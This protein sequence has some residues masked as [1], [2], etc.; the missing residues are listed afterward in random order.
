M[1]IVNGFKKEPQPNCIYLRRVKW[2]DYSY[3]I[4]FNL[5][6]F[7]EGLVEHKIG[8]VKIAYKGLSC[9]EHTADSLPDQFSSLTP[10]Y[11]S[12]GQNPEYYQNIMECLGP[13]SGA[14]V[15][16]ALRDVVIEESWLQECK[17][18]RWFEDSLKRYVSFETINGQFRRIVSQGSKLESYG[19]VFETA[20]AKAN[21]TFE[22]KPGSKP[23]TNIHVLTGRNGAG[24]THT[25]KKLAKT[26]IERDSGSG[27]VKD[28][29]G[30]VEFYFSRTVYASF[31]VFDN[32]LE[33]IKFDDPVDGAP[34][35]V[36]VGL[37]SAEIN[38][39]ND[40]GVKYKVKSRL[41]LAEEFCDSLKNCII[42]SEQKR[43]VWREVV[44]VLESDA[45]FSEYSIKDLADL[46]ESRL[47]STALATFSLLSSGHAAVLYSL[48]KIVELTEEKTVVIFD[49]PENHLHPPLLSAF[50]RALSKLLA[51]KNGIAIMSTHSPVIVQE[52]PASCVW[53]IDRIGANMTA[54]RPSLETF[55]E[56]VGTLTH[57]VFSL[58]VTR[59]G[60]YALLDSD[61]LELGSYDAVMERYRRQIGLEGRLV[62]R[63]LVSQAK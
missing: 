8:E 16:R 45:N 26:I 43:E 27:R 46:E 17:E 31:S 35:S 52:V 13:N 50:V 49:E 59:S 42:G 25:L 15:L 5:S 24:K 12:L 32:P 10:E 38:Q 11:F 40:S 19:F 6:Y 22:V 21:L 23:P 14:S 60:F 41:E 62:L 2:D 7:D 28:S 48:T 54:A 51:D 34:N 63:A 53:K 29:Q 9:L 44:S 39:A 36:Y 56:N 18:E 37:Y 47:Y 1:E 30:A 4:S 61:A 55:A 58:E 57:E 20:D 3:W 33:E